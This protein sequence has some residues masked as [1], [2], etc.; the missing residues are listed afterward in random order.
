M[1]GADRHLRGTT[2]LRTNMR[3]SAN[4]HQTKAFGPKVYR[5]KIC[6]QKKVY[7]RN[8]KKVKRFAF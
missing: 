6:N 7:Q 4:E 1:L 5:M 2:K 8:T 3:K